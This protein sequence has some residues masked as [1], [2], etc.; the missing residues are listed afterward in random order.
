MMN[1]A[2]AASDDTV[3]TWFHA[4]QSLRYPPHARAGGA[5][6]LF[7][8]D[9]EHHR[10]EDCADQVKET[11]GNEVDGGRPRPSNK[12]GNRQQNGE[13]GRS[14]ERGEKQRLQDR[15]V[16]GLHYGNATGRRQAPEGLHITKAEKAM[17]IPAINPEPR[18]ARNVNANSKPSITCTTALT[19][20]HGLS[21]HRRHPKS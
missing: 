4:V 18:A 3:R 13:R 14:E 6:R 19:E 15:D 5:F 12:C 21:R 16:D 10:H 9:I 8:R 17:K 2:A 11:A 20:S 7:K 1:D